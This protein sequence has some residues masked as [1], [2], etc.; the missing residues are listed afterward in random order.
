MGGK[1][2]CGILAEARAGERLRVVLG[3]GVN[4][5]AVPEGLEDTAGAFSKPRPRSPG[6]GSPPGY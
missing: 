5:S 1:K 6:K 2:V 4:V 3:V